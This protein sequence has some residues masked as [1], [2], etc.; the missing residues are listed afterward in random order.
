MWLDRQTHQRSKDLLLLPLILPFPLSS[1]LLFLIKTMLSW[2]KK[3]VR[4]FGNILRK[5]LNGLLGQ[6]SSF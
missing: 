2:P 3:F 4:V 5:N 6:P 1:F